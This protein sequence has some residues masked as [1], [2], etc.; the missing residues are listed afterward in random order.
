MWLLSLS[1]VSSRLAAVLLSFLCLSSLSVVLSDSFPSITLEYSASVVLTYG[2][3]NYSSIF[4]EYVSGS[5][6]AEVTE[7]I[8]EQR[9]R[10]VDANIWLYADELNDDLML[11]SAANGD[12]TAPF[13]SCLEIK[14]VLNAAGINV[15]NSL[16]VGPSFGLFRILAGIVVEWTV[17]QNVFLQE[18]CRLTSIIWLYKDH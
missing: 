18:T 16:S 17:T 1:S 11:I 14:S 12:V 9:G 15:W 3:Y 13:T 10:Y 5:T 7:A 8:F 2:S 4:D 6:S